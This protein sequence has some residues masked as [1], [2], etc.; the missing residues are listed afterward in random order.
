MITVTDDVDSLQ[1]HQTPSCFGL[2]CERTFI[3]AI[4][5]DMPIGHFMTWCAMTSLAI[6][7]YVAPFATLETSWFAAINWD[8][9][10]VFVA[11]KSHHLTLV[12]DIR[13]FSLLPEV[14]SGFCGSLSKDLLPWVL[15]CANKWCFQFHHVR[16]NSVIDLFITEPQR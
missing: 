9:N 12:G 4:G 16:W 15:H 10:S 5:S 13:F 11:V 14:S 6:A 1:V 2:Y 8:E 3:R 7:A